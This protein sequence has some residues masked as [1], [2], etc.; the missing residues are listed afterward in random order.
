MALN[1]LFVQF[2]IIQTIVKQIFIENLTFKHYRY[3]HRTVTLKLT[4]FQ[5]KSQIFIVIYSKA[6]IFYC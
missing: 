4:L 2:F 6:D 3:R 1:Q 5:T